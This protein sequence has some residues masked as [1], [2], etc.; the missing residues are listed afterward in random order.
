[1]TLDELIDELTTK[2]DVLK[3]RGFTGDVAVY[4]PDRDDETSFSPLLT[5]EIDYI[6][7]GTMADIILDA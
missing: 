7:R 6:E 5:V 4:L 1:M 2:R 3:E